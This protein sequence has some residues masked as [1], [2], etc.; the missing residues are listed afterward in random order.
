MLD[1]DAGRY[2]AF[3][4]PAYGITVLVFAVLIVTALRHARRWRRRA[5]GRGR[6]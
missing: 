1:L 6:R 2:A 4:W 3:V 5:E